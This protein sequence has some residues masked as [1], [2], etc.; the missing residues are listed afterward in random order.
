MH[1]FFHGTAGQD[2][3]GT[4]EAGDLFDVDR[5]GVRNLAEAA[6]AASG[7]ETYAEDANSLVGAKRGQNYLSL[8]GRAGLR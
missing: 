7:I 2:D 6:R 8:D 3:G 4:Y 5:D 1:Y